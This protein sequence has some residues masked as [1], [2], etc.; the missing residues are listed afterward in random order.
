M[1]RF[2]LVDPDEP[3]QKHRHGFAT[4]MKLVENAIERNIMDAR[5]RAMAISKL[6]ELYLIIKQGIRNDQIKRLRGG[7]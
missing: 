1:N 6:E 2:D 7:E 5:I 4:M 3:A